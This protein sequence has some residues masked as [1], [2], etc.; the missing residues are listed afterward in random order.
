MG[1]L[2]RRRLE[3][4]H[5]RLQEEHRA[6]LA[7]LASKIDGFSSHLEHE[8][9]YMKITGGFGEVPKLDRRVKALVE[10]GRGLRTQL[11]R[12]ERQET[13]DIADYPVDEA[14]AWVEDAEALL[15][16]YYTAL[17]RWA[18]QLPA[19]GPPYDNLSAG[20]QEQEF[21]RL[22]ALNEPIPYEFGG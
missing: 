15:D 10:D 6:Q 1:W 2:K 18:K 8:S 4:E 3:R 22:R 14:N 11:G 20:E 21:A 16:D 5:R 19:L 9:G 12:A 17:R 13:V 7:E